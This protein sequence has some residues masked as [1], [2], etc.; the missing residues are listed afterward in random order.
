MSHD[1]VSYAPEQRIEYLGGFFAVFK[2]IAIVCLRV[3]WLLHAQ[4]RS[5]EGTAEVLCRSCRNEEIYRH[6]KLREMPA[7]SSVG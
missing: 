5:Y 3:N 6:D 4:A 1:I 2:K 7:H